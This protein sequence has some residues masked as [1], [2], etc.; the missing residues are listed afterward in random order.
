MI[1]DEYTDLNISR[2][3]KWNLRNPDKLA[4]YKH[5][6]KTSD[7]GKESNRRYY[8]KHKPVD[9]SNTLSDN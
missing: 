2:Q 5:R 3:Q 9:K 1:H 4:A 8:E 7:K 6:W